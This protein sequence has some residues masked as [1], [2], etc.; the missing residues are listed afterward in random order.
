MILLHHP[1]VAA[2]T[3]YAVIASLTWGNTSAGTL[4]LAVIVLAGQWFSRRRTQ[5]IQITLDGQRKALEDRIAQLEA[6]I[7]ESNK[8]VPATTR[9]T[10]R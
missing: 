10:G 2:Y 6:T 3:S 5:S 7:E 8:E 9:E 1:F 4:V